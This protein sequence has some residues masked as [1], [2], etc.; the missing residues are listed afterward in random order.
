MHLVPMAPLG[1]LCN[2]LL[3]VH[4]TNQRTIF[5]TSNVAR[6][7]GGS[8]EAHCQVKLWLETTYSLSLAVPRMFIYEFFLKILKLYSKTQY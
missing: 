8:V 3:G 7:S 4:G 6:W 5:F 2:E 1:L